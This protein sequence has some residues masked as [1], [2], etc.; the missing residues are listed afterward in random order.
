MN[1]PIK[2]D[3]EHIELLADLFSLLGDQTRLQVVLACLNA[4]I[5]VSDIAKKL[6]LSTSLISHH[7]R[8]LRAA[9]IVHGERQGKNIFCTVDDHHIR[10]ML[11][12]LLEHIS[13]PHDD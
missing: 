13:E 2:A 12:N 4:P 5:T 6:N 8:L 7:L 3:V 11:S 1:A 10:T 9:R